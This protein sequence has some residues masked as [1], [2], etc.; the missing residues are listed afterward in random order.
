M[1]TAGR[2]TGGSWA[3]AA[4][5]AA[6]MLTGWLWLDPL[7]SL[8]IVAVIL[9]STWGLLRDSIGLALA[10]VEAGKLY[11]VPH[12]EIRWLWR[13]KRL[14]PP[15]FAWLTTRLGRRAFLPER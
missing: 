5:G 10:A 9:W 7:T 14:S 15:L 11:A 2:E 3:N 4:A 13:V 8:A 1:V 12:A 6:I